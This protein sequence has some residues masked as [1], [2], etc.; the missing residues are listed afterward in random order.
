MIVQNFHN[1][2]KNGFTRVI[3]RSWSLQIPK[4]EKGEAAATI[5]KAPSKSQNT[6]I[7]PRS[8]LCPV[9]TTRLAGL[10]ALHQVIFFFSSFFL[11]P[12]CS[13]LLSWNSVMGFFNFVVF[14]VGIDNWII[15]RIVCS[16][17]HFSLNSISVPLL[18]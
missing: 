17:F 15:W 1:Y 13:I 14:S 10:T 2:L 18:Q 3:N 11:I 6:H 5:L 7:V 9:S 16:R 12:I 4:S 8:C